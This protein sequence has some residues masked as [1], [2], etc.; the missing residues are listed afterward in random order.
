[1]EDKDILKLNKLINQSSEEFGLDMTVEVNSISDPLNLEV[2]IKGIGAF[3]FKDKEALL[4]IHDP[5]L[6]LAK[7]HNVSKSHLLAFYSANN[8]DLNRCQSLTKKGTR[9]MR[10]SKITVSGINDYVPQ[11]VYLCHHHEKHGLLTK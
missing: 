10:M 1:M 7:K 11:K 2:G 8:D 9:C 4:F 6:G 5:V 3:N